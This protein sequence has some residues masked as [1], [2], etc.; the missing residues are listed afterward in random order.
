MLARKLTHT[1]WCV[2]S[3]T[4]LS[5]ARTCR[6]AVTIPIEGSGRKGA[7][8]TAARV[9]TDRRPLASAPNSSHASRLHNVESLSQL[10]SPH[11]PGAGRFFFRAEMAHLFGE[12]CAHEATWKPHEKHGNL[13]AQSDLPDSVYAFPKE[14][15]EPLTDARH[16]RNAIARFDQ[17][18]GVP[19]A[20]RELAFANIKKAAAYYGVELSEKSWHDLGVHPQRNR[21]QQCAQRAS[22][23]ASVRVRQS[24]PPTRAP[25]LESAPASRKAPVASS[26]T[27]KRNVRKR[28]R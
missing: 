23:R 11:A 16:V 19:D 25:Q 2:R 1:A 28:S 21:K 10:E 7:Y 9:T 5:L 12:N 15:K 17:V 13:N 24:E 6:S 14:R 26:A 22:Q 4:F 27:R 18:T 20:D 3:S 8:A